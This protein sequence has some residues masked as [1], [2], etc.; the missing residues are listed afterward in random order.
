MRFF[1]VGI[2][3]LCSGRML[4]LVGALD[5]MPIHCWLEKPGSQEPEFD[6]APLFPPPGHFSFLSPQSAGDPEVFCPLEGDLFFPP[7]PPRSTSRWSGA[8]PNCRWSRTPPWIL[9]L[10]V[11]PSSFPPRRPCCLHPSPPP[12]LTV[13]HRV[14]GPFAVHQT[15]EDRLLVLPS[16][17]PPRTD[18]PFFFRRGSL[19]AALTLY[20]SFAVR[21]SP[22]Q[23]RLA[24]FSLNFSIPIPTRPF[25]RP[26][27]SSGLRRFLG[28]TSC[29]QNV[30]PFF[31]ICTGVSPPQTLSLGRVFFVGCLFFRFTSGIPLFIVDLPNFIISFS[32]SLWYS[33]SY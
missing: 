26:G 28:P 30:R 14:F 19:F 9:A 20:I 4:L 6:F 27:S 5:G 22:S 18:R 21:L 1:S 11:D 33:P 7:F 12:F 17:S 10:V 24:V 8:P 31:W 25:S 15:P 13:D 2:A 23:A 3:F 16:P 32:Y 29:S